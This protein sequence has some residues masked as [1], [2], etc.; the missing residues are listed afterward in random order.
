M[1]RRTFRSLLIADADASSRQVRAAGLRSLALGAALAVGAF[2]AIAR[3][4]SGARP[5]VRLLLLALVG[6]GYILGAQGAYR[7][8]TGIA[9]GAEVPERG[10]ALRAVFGLVAIAGFFAAA[11]VSLATLNAPPPTSSGPQPQGREIA[12]PFPTEGQNEVRYQ[13]GDASLTIIRV[14]HESDAGRP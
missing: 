10:R 4:G 7:A 3:W 2:A 14:Q 13:I 1:N 8:L 12:L 5:V 9:R 6:T 11:F